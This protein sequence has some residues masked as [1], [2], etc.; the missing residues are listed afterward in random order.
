MALPVNSN[1]SM[2]PW[3]SDVR[4]QNHRKPGSQGKVWPLISR[5]KRM[6][7]FQAYRVHPETAKPITRFD[8]IEVSVSN[9]KTTI[10]S[11]TNILTE[12]NTAGLVIREFEDS[13]YDLVTYP[14]TTAM[15]TAIANEGTYYAVMSDAIDGVGNTWYS[16]VF[17][18]K[19][20][21]EGFLKLS[22]WHDEGF[23]VPEHHISYAEPFA[24]FVYLKD[25]PFKPI[26]Q[27]SPQVNEVDGYPYQLYI[28]SKKTF[29]FVVLLPE[30]MMDLL[31]LVGQHYYVT[32]EYDGLTYNV[33]W[34]NPI[35]GE[36]EKHGDLCSM[37]FQFL[38]DTVVATTGRLKPEGQ[39]FAYDQTGYSEGYS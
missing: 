7:P 12:V 1:Y 27:S 28:W 15:T 31:R 19:S 29:R 38:T 2:L 4:Y 11:T 13:G 20:S 32:I 30:Y 34:I 37:E 6:P 10:L 25:G 33:L 3:Y 9:G 35:Q 39:G 16:E 5:T 21:V 24:N 22:F 14:G 36:W 8:L 18:V 26:Y 23:A 17:C